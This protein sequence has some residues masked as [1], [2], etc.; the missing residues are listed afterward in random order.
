MLTCNYCTHADILKLP[1]KFF[2]RRKLRSCDTIE[3][4][5]TISPLVFLESN[6]QE[7]YS[8]D[9]GS[10]LNINEA[11]QVVTFLKETLLLKWPT[12]LWGSYLSSIAILSTEYA[13]V[14][15]NNM[16]N[17]LWF[18]KFCPGEVYSL[19]TKGGKNAND[20]C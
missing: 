1:S 14:C 2:Y 12:D 15:I 7:N 9:Y 16:Y 5:S 11:E 13:Q 3:K 6:D 20:I 10:Y 4:H 18:I 19:S 17:G 8:P